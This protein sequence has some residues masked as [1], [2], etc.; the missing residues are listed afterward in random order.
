MASERSALFSKPL[1]LNKKFMKLQG[2]KVASNDNFK[3][4][5]FMQTTSETV[6]SGDIAEQAARLAE[7]TENKIN[8][9]KSKEAEQYWRIRRL[10]RIDAK[11]TKGCCIEMRSAKLRMGEV[12]EEDMDENGMIK[13][14]ERWDFK[15]SLR[16]VERQVKRK[17]IELKFDLEYEIE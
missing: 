14:E 2:R 17:Q 9:V 6:I 16:E 10:Q 4:H 11:P 5:P 3:D 13:D 8:M 15:K 1:S 12:K 7:E